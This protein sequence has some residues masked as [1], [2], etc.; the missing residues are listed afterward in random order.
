MT[1]IVLLI[2]LSCQV[3]C[4]QWPTAAKNGFGTS[5]TV[6]SKVWFTLADGVM[7]EVFYPTIDMPKVRTLQFQVVMNS[8]I[9]NEIDDTVHRLELP[10]AS[11]LTF[12]QIN[13]A[14][15]GAYT[16]TKTYIT[17]PRR[18]SVLIRVDFNTTTN[19]QLHVSYDPLPND[20]SALISSCGLPK[21]EQRQCTLALGFGETTAKAASTARASL[22]RGFEATQTEY[23]DEWRSYVSQ[24]P[25]VAKHQQQFNLAAMILK[26]LEDKTYRG[27]VIASP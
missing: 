9:E 21:L 23:E 20:K 14:Q 24:L 16:I 13:R 19:G 27:A 26:G 22:A 15:S 1:R 6:A 11:S 3:V 12:R 10:N 4:A 7:T 8:K 25:R 18:S 17:D 2:L 5:N